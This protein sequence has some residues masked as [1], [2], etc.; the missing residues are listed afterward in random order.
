MLVALR[1]GF[2]YIFERSFGEGFLDNFIDF[3]F[4]FVIWSFPKYIEI[5][6]KLVIITVQPVSIT[7]KRIIRA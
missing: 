6:V 1:I 3:L 4:S 2:L 5:F 7:D